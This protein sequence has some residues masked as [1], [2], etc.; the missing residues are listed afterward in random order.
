MQFQLACKYCH[1]PFAIESEGGSTLR[2]NCPYCGKSMMV[3]TPQVGAPTGSVAEMATSAGQTPL[4]RNVRNVQGGSSMYRKTSGSQLGKKVTIAFVCFLVFVIL[5]L[6][7]LYMV[8][9][10]MSN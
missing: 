3:A 1:Q 6:S 2:C 9:S 7:L 8:F 10:A 4:D 5:M